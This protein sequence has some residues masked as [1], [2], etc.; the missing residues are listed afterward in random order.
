MN[1]L[2]NYSLKNLNTFGIDVTAGYFLE[3]NSE[4][5]LPEFINLP[6][7]KSKPILILGG[8]SNIL[9]TKDFDGI[10]VRYSKKGINIISESSADVFV[11]ANAGELWN[12]LVDYAV[13]NKLYGIENLTL[14]PGTVGAAPIQNI[15]AYGV[16][17][18]DV[19]HC[20]E[21]FD[22]SEGRLKRLSNTEC[23]F[24]Y[25]NS[26]FKNEL[27]GKFLI[28][29]I[30]LK[31]SEEKKFN[32]SYK[33]LKEELVKYSGDELTIDLISKTVKEIR[34][35]KLPDPK[36]IGNAGS[37]FKNPELDSISFNVFIEKNPDAVF[38]QQ[39]N[40]FKISAG[41]L[42][43][44]CGFKGKRIGNVGSYEKQSLI[45]VNYG[46][47]KGLEIKEFSDRII[48]EVKNKFDIQLIHEVNIIQ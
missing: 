4:Q 15:G 33:S 44:K 37:F 45:I 2:K 48:N 36:I 29:K 24:A 43:E 17:L 42:I 38:H 31:L 6:V 28:T 35:N 46:N 32:L 23:R 27:K 30:V 40:V 13:K 26:I 1:L 18:K 47:A 16:E 9:F 41:W 22:L 20:V 3:I 7:S 10:V 14:I 21:Y 34:K 8:G 25:R 11:E 5:E 39:G 12:D 19:L